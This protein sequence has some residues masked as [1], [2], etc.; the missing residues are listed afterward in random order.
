M[1]QRPPV[2]RPAQ[3][4]TAQPQRP[5]QRPAGNPAARPAQPQRAARPAG[6]QS[7]RPAQQAPVS[8]GDNNLIRNILVGMGVVAVLVLAFI[9]QFKVFP[10]GRVLYEE[11]HSAGE[12]NKLA[13]EIS[14]NI[15]TIP[16]DREAFSEV[17]SD[18]CVIESNTVN[19]TVQE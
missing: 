4:R 11:G 9:L 17:K 19:G 15:L 8:G 7:Q 3:G 6:A 13:A 2:Q 14:G 12:E 16:A 10:D 5:V 1:Q 18:T